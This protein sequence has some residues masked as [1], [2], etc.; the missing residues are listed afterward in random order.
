M[1]VTE[2]R[3]LRY[4]VLPGASG[5]RRSHL[6]PYLLRLQLLNL[7][8]EVAELLAFGRLLGRGLLTLGLLAGDRA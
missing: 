5:C 7:L 4:Q 6:R 3:E 8:L 2:T 1:Q